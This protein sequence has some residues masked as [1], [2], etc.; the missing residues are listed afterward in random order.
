MIPEQGVLKQEPRPV[1][2]NA[3]L[4]GRDGTPRRRWY[5]LAERRAGVSAA[6]REAT[7]GLSEGGTG[8]VTPRKVFHSVPFCA[9]S[10]VAGGTPGHSLGRF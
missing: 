3:L 5:G 8:G 10:Y 2:L 1:E 4:M 9:V 7:A 6:L